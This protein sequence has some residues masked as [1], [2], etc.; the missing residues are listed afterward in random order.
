MVEHRT[1]QRHRSE[2]PTIR[3]LI[4][5]AIDAGKSVR[6]L[7][8]DAGFRVKHQTFQELSKHAPKQFP[9]DAKTI[10]GMSLALGYPEATIVLA[11]AKGLGINVETDSEFALRLPTGVDGL[12]PEMQSALVSVARAAVNQQKESPHAD[13]PADTDPS[14]ESRASSP[15]TEDQKTGAADGRGNYDLAGRDVGGISEAEYIRRQQERAA[16]L[17]DL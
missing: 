16:E 6:D 5:E 8:A 11:Y 9:K 7:A 2:V 1:A 12:T 3:E 4:Q 10:A 14:E 13:Q 15:P 17:G